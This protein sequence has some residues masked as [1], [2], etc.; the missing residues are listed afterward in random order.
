MIIMAVCLACLSVQVG[1]AVISGGTGS[2]DLQQKVVRGVV[3]DE[4]GKPFPFV[5][6]YVENRTTIGVVTNDAGEY[7]ISVPEGS[8]LCFAF[9]GYRTLTYEVGTNEVIN[10]KMEPEMKAMMKLSW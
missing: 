1:A 4:T 3:T 9:V 10:V 7:R 6:V 8:S 5:T 2:P